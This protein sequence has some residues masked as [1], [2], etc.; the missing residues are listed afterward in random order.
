MFQ[1]T[2][3]SLSNGA[4]PAVF[5]GNNGSSLARRGLLRCD[6][7]GNVPAGAVI[8]DVSLTMN[9]SIATNAILRTFT[10][11]RVLHS[12]GEGTSSTGGGAGAAATPGDATWRHRFW[13]DE[14]WDNAGG[15]FAAAVSGA[16]SVGDVGFY[17]WTDPAMAADV[18][19]WLDDSTHNFGWALIGDE[20]LAN[21]A[22]RFDSREHPTADVRPA[23]TIHYSSSVGVGDGVTPD[24]VALAPCH[25]NPAAGTARFEFWLPSPGRATLTVTDVVGRCVATLID[26]PLDRGRYSCLWTGRDRGG[27]AVASGVY[28]YRLVVDGRTRGARRLVML[29]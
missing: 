22:R 1:D 16:Q 10:L 2:T 3:G 7:A 19:S 15:D 9:V 20:T 5:A 14:R 24:D 6:V 11:H 13:P 28:F 26:R 17:T 4:G 8:G 21:T 18:Q 29:P 12:W 27:H 25:P 23:L